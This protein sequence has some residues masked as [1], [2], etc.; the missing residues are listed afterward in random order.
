[1]S[2]WG[3]TTSFAAAT[4]LPTSSACSTILLG[5]YRLQPTGAA[6]YTQKNPR[7]DAPEAVGGSL[8]VA[9]FNL[10]NFFTT[11]TGSEVCGAGQNL[12]C[13]GADTEEEFERQRAK[14]IEALLGLDADIV[15]LIELENTPG[16]DPLG[17]LAVGLNA[18]LGEDTYRAIQ[19]GA[20]GT[21]AIRVGILYKTDAVVPVGETATLSEPASVF[22]GPGTGRV[23][24][25]Q[26]F[27]TQTGGAF[28]VVV[29]HFKS[30]GCSGA[31]GANRDSGQGCYNARRTE[32]AE[33]T[34]AWLET[35]PT[36]VTDPDVLFVG[37][38]NAYDE[39]SPID[40][41]E[42]AGY[43]DLVETYGGEFAYSYVF[44]GLFG[45]LDYALA[46]APLLPQVTGSTEWHINADEPDIWD[47]DTSY[48]NPVY[49]QANPYR[50]SDH[51]PVLVG[52]DLSPD[53]L[54]V[55]EALQREAGALGSGSDISASALEQIQ[56]SLQADETAT[57]LDGLGA[58]R[59]GLEG[60][61][62][63]PEAR[64]RLLFL[65]DALMN[66][67]R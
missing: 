59:E 51:D 9:S 40:A 37:D 31:E 43:T 10:L 29:N 33:A 58:F 21:D 13:R 34:A 18:R 38:L 14:I 35:N 39:E 65:T 11:L 17:S 49:Y 2:L 28:T 60:E 48:N 16:A 56:T 54:V 61:A 8:R 67:L 32:A 53:P 15:G 23:P 12:G 42:A 22:V 50:T 4:R 62:V 57:A 5:G 6:D 64:Q 27:I 3:R 19:T 41:L 52:L 7:P 66:A 26:S 24:L 47:Y 1:M 36:G 20:L 30:K 63:A 45:Y 44:D 25:A 55:L 46:N